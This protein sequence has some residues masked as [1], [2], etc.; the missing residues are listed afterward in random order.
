[1]SKLSGTGWRILAVMAVLGG[2]AACSAGPPVAEPEPAVVDL[3]QAEQAQ[4][5]APANEA[6]PAQTPATP[7]QEVAV[8]NPDN[9]LA[10]LAS[11]R[12]A[13]LES[14]GDT[15]ETSEV[16]YYV[17]ILE[18][19]FKRVHD[20]NIDIVRQGKTF[21]LVIAGSDAFD[22]NRSALKPGIVAALTTIAGVLEE[23]RNTQVSIY[24]HT[25]DTGEEAYNQKLSEK[26]ALAVARFLIDAGI[27]AERILVIGYGESRP[28]VE[29]S[30]EENRARNRRIEMNLEPL[31]R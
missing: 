27:A 17:D 9:D 16:G 1:M 6:P 18:A 31:A 21:T 4:A 24:G 14:G 13:L 10:E 7:R 26:R 29:N 15:L 2:L 12:E 25:D 30:S 5:E 8:L 20:D 3:P 19:R 28:V 22:S 23:Y 11:H